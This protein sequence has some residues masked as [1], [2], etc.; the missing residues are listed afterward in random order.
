MTF[1]NT[2]WHLYKSFIVVYETRNLQRAADILLV[3]R[4]AV[5]QNLKELSNQL[6]VTLFTSHSKGVMPTGEANNLY[7][8]IKNAILAIVDAENGLQAFTSES[9]G[10]IRIAVPDQVV[11]WLIADYLQE[12]CVKY[13]KVRFE[14]YRLKGLN[15]LII[16]NVDFLFD[17]KHKITGNELKITDLFFL[18]GNLIASRAFLKKQGLSDKISKEDFL[19]LPII[20][21]P[22]DPLAEFYKQLSPSAEPFVLKT[23]TYNL[24][25]FLATN[26][27]G[28][29]WSSKELFRKRN[30]PNLIEVSVGG[31]AL[32]VS[33]ISCAH[34]QNLSRAARAFIEGLLKVCKSS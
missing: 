4:S 21:Y 33:I 8:I 27:L 7:P 10:I 13:P 11:D 32:P 31:I 12:F 15:E 29:G 9:T 24:T 1:N 34:N 20:T 22:T 3:S 23:D 19:R 6:G 2:N 26:G 17:F 30:E 28:V 14:F 16:G 5:S 25:H 18:H